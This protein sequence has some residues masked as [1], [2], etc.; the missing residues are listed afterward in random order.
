L[1][2]PLG[3]LLALGLDRI[4]RRMP[5]LPDGLHFFVF[6]PRALEWHA[7]L[8]GATAVAAALYPI[9]LAVKLPIA[10]TLRQETVS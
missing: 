4:L 5:G 10:Q 6:E 2:V 9:W 3:G 1:A 7:A 8:L